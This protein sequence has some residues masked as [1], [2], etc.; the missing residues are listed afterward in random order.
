MLSSFICLPAKMSLFKQKARGDCQHFSR[1]RKVPS[2]NVSRPLPSARC[3]HA[4]LLH[5]GNALPLFHTLFDAKNRVSRL[6]VNLNLFACQRLDLD[7]DATA[8]GNVPSQAA[9]IRDAVVSQA[10]GSVEGAGNARTAY[11]AAR[12]NSTGRANFVCKSTSN[13]WMNTPSP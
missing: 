6:D 9:P 5:G 10:L 1:T 4:P 13:M 3:K 7:H 12:W 2:P 11:M 8:Q